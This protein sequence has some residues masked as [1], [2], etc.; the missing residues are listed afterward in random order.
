[1]IYVQPNNPFSTIKSTPM[2][3]IT[4]GRIK[5]LHCSSEDQTCSGHDLEG[6]LSEMN[7]L[8]IIRAARL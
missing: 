2:C 3:V 6:L 4:S 8:N 5:L 1:M 7:K